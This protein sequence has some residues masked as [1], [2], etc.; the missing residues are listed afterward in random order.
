MYRFL[1]FLL[2]ITNLNAQTVFVIDSLTALPLENV[3]IFTVDTS[4]YAISD[5]FGKF[6]LSVFYP[7]D[8]LIFSHISY[9]K[10]HIKANR[11]KINS[12][13]YLIPS[14]FNTEDVNVIDK[15]INKDLQSF[16]E[17]IN[18]TPETKTIYLN[19]GD[20]LKSKSSLFIRDYGGFGG[21]KTASTRGLSSENTVVLFNEARINDLRTGLV[22]LSTIGTASMDKIS[23]QKNAGD[24]VDFP[25]AG[26]VLKIYSDQSFKGEKLNAGLKLSSDKYQSAVINYKGGSE[27]LFYSLSGER[28]FSS[29]HYSYIFN[30]IRLKRENADFNKSFL[31]ADINYKTDKTKFSFYINYLHL[32]SGIPGFVVTNNYSSSRAQNLN[33]SILNILNSEIVLSDNWQYNGVFYFN[34]QELAINDPDGIVVF[35]DSKK[36]SRLSEYSFQNKMSFS[37]GVLSFNL[38]YTASFSQLNNITSFVSSND[39]PQKISSIKHSIFGGGNYSFIKPLAFPFIIRI[40]SGAGVQMLNEKLQKENHSQNIFYRTGIALFPVRLPQLVFK[41][42]YAKE[43]RVPTFNER[44]YSNLF[45]HYELKQEKYN[46]FDA[47]VDAEIGLEDVLELSVVY[48]DIR[49]KDKIIWIP[50]RLAIQTPR[51]IAEVESKGLEFTA[52][53]KLLNKKMDLYFVYNYSDA[54]N[55]TRLS[56]TD[57]NFNKQLIYTPLHKLN[58]GISYTDDSFFISVN[59]SFVSQRYYTSDNNPLYLLPDYFVF[60]LSGGITFKFSEL[61]HRFSITAYNLFDEK[62]FVIQSYPMPLRTYLLTYSMEIK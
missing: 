33:R 17:E 29:N 28:A 26:G 50:T 45:N 53:Q 14:S 54:R 20:I 37:K 51:N 24:D 4:R 42:H 35:A 46:S 55:K 23:Y 57:Y 40:S 31:S 61:T 10:K 1:F 5:R 41:A 19:I 47:G 52:N 2:F 62:Y 58:A 32:Q 38:I 48:Y 16:N 15:K 36:D 27:N 59:S 13:I 43:Y 11:L 49:G 21:V 6:D 7:D 8:E 56:A 44:Y 18:L 39:S 34:H 9:L 30:N 12:R 60:D 3:N 25:A 22:D